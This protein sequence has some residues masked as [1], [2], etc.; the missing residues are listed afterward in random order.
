MVRRYMPLGPTLEETLSE[1]F[2]AKKRKNLLYYRRSLAK[3]YDVEFVPWIAADEAEAAVLELARHS[4]PRRSR[5]EVGF[6]CEFLRRHAQ[7]FCM[8]LRLTDGAWLSLVTGWR[9]DGITHMPW[10]LN[11][12]E[13]R[14]ESLMQV[15]RTYVMEH[16]CALGQTALSW[17]GGTVAFQ[18]ACDPESCL[19]IIE[20]RRGVRSSL[21]RSV[22]APYLFQRNPHAFTGGSLMLLLPAQSRGFPGA[23]LGPDS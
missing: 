10:Q 22:L 7:S 20:A 17:V 18:T 16:E 13:F 2:T 5:R 23:C 21:L 12:D 11:H 15:M 14:D 9:A 1:R 8:G 3:K 6:H 4:W 19:D